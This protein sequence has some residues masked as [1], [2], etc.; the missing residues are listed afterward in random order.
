MK[1]TMWQLR[2]I[3]YEASQDFQPD[4]LL[5]DD[6]A[7]KQGYNRLPINADFGKDGWQITDDVYASSL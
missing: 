3:I 4:A 5:F 2:Q 7:A 1:I 6:L